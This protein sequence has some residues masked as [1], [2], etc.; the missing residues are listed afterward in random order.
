MNDY[1]EILE[2]NATEVLPAGDKELQR[3]PE[4]SRRVRLL[5]N[6]YIRCTEFKRLMNQIVMAQVNGGFRSVAILSEFAGE[7]K[8][9]FAAALALAYA[10]YLVGRVLIVDTVRQPNN[11]TLYHKA[12]R[13]QYA[14]DTLQSQPDVSPGLVDLLTTGETEAAA[15]GTSD[16]I[17]CSY[18][19]TIK[20]RYDLVIVDTCAMAGANKDNIDPIIAARH[21]DTSILITS[22]RSV[23]RVALDNIKRKFEQ[24]SISVLGTIFNR[25]TLR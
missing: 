7:G 10:K 15:H 4:H 19:D 21:I 23:E 2:G 13:G 20:H 12:I 14:P 16:F 18:I 3:S 24:Y 17:L 8:T 22:N 1:F 5:L 25:G 9:F 11:H 6:D